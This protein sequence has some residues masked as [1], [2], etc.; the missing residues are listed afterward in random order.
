MIPKDHVRGTKFPAK[1]QKHDST[2]LAWF[3]LRL[4]VCVHIDRGT[5]LYVCARLHTYVYEGPELLNIRDRINASRNSQ[6]FFEQRVTRFQAKI[7]AQEGGR[8]IAWGGTRR[9]NFENPSQYKRTRVLFD[10]KG[11]IKG[12][13]DA[14]GVHSDVFNKRRWFTMVKQRAIE[15]KKREWYEFQNS[16]KELGERAWQ[17]V[18]REGVTVDVECRERLSRLGQEQAFS[19]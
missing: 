13:F 11:T 5:R 10:G 17:R 15:M 14:N 7:T 6:I 4:C 19:H 16:L 18:A 9:T 8:G 2:R 1:R 3:R 12:T